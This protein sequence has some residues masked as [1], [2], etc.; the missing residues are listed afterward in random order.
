MNTSL[1]RRK[2][3]QRAP[4][5]L[6]S[7]GLVKPLLSPS[8]IDPVDQRK[9]IE[10][11][12]ATICLDGFGNE[13]FEPTFEMAPQIG[14]KNI[15]FNVWYGRN[16]TPGGIARIQDRCY[17][18][19]LRPIS[20]QGTSFGGHV[21]KDV[22]HKLWLMEKAQALGC[23]RVKFTGS[24][25]GEAGGLENVIQVLKELAPAAEE[26]DMLI[27]VENH[28]NNNIEN[29]ADYEAIFEVIDSSHVG[30]CLDM[31]HFDGAGVNNFEVIERFPQKINHVDLKD[32]LAFG[33]Y[34]TVPFGEGATDGPGIVKALIEKG[35]SGYLVIEQAP[36]I[37]GKDLVKEM[38][39][40]KEM[41]VGF[42]R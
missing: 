11:A 20:L 10:L 1:K 31:G 38:R 14:I 33:T 32:T 35:Y 23:R 21:T 39:R 42:E 36:P 18:K 40:V 3:V 19:G 6:A 5:I 8:A 15:E 27:A 2:F 29:I 17:Q 7:L 22:G 25:R 30:I 24:K 41:F 26:M 4:A 12:I 16:I 34:K 37:E 13:D 9:G 28:A